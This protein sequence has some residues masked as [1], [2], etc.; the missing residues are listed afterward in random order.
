MKINFLK[1][2]D[3]HSFFINDLCLKTKAFIKKT[4]GGEIIKM[5][6]AGH[7]VMNIIPQDPLC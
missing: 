3:C 1:G 5:K 7:I 4:E 2:E 6:V